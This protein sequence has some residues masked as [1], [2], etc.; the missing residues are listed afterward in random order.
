MIQVQ[1]VQGE[2]PFP[3]GERAHALEE[4]ELSPG[5][6][7]MNQ[8]EI[9]SNNNIVN[10]IVALTEQ[11]NSTKDTGALL[12]ES[13]LSGAFLLAKNAEQNKFEYHEHLVHR[14]FVDSKCTHVRYDRDASGRLVKW[15]QKLKRGE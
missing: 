15:W 5:E 10:G 11:E 4:Q 9:N 7:M 12:M 2:S 3:F 14:Y 6:Q 13:S 8:L 1:Y